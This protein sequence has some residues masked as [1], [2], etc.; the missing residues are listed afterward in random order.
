MLPRSSFAHFPIDGSAIGALT[1]S[2]PPRNPR[3]EDTPRSR[4]FRIGFLVV[5][6]SPAGDVTNQEIIGQLGFT[7]QWARSY[8]ITSSRPSTTLCI[9]G[10]PSSQQAS[11]WKIWFNRVGTYP[12]PP[13]SLPSITLSIALNIEASGSFSGFCVYWVIPESVNLA[14]SF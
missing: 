4:V 10:S 12:I 2:P 14:L 9:W 11:S 3:D 8:S 13:A 6:I 1:Q 5:V 7:A